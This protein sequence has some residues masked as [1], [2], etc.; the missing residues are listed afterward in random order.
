VVLLEHPLIILQYVSGL[1]CDVNI[2]DCESN[3]CQNGGNCTDHVNFYTCQCPH[4]YEG[5]NCQRESNPC[6]VN[7]CLRGKFYLWISVFFSEINWLSSGKFRLTICS[8]HIYLP[9]CLS[10]ETAKGPLRSSS[11]AA[12]CYYPSSHPKEEASHPVK[13]LSQR[14]NKRN[15][16]LDLHSIS[17]KLS[18]KHRSC[19]I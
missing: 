16:R 18:V 12:T 5:T 19:V 8:L 6:R 14:D 7:P 17:L 15:C 10:Q 11:R 13:R 4:P 3:P 1:Q 9:I 2:N